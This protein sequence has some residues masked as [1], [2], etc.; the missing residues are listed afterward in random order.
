M[1]VRPSKRRPSAEEAAKY[2]LSCL[3][4]FTSSDDFDRDVDFIDGTWGIVALGEPAVQLD[5]DSGFGTL[6]R[7]LGLDGNCDYPAFAV[8][9]DGYQALVWDDGGVWIVAPWLLDSKTR[10]AYRIDKPEG[11]LDF[12]LLK[13]SPLTAKDRYKRFRVSY[14]AKLDRVHYGKERNEII[15][16]CLGKY[17]DSTGAPVQ[18]RMPYPILSEREVLEGPAWGES[19]KEIRSCS[20]RET[21]IDEISGVER[22]DG[23]L[24]CS[25]R[26]IESVW[27]DGDCISHHPSQITR[28]V[29]LRMARPIFDCL[30]RS[31]QEEVLRAGGKEFL[32]RVDEAVKHNPKL[33]VLPF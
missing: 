31:T 26:V 2:F 10:E 29:P 22:A 6:F 18:L 15:V 21:F 3:E 7:E 24:V 4:G 25:G 27:K 5:P 19:E 13:V 11:G 32:R 30:K 1:A 28:N 16:F 8:E 23:G 17:I 33:G 20:V 9:K 12:D 14:L